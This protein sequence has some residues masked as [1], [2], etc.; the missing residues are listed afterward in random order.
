[1]IDWFLIL[2][3]FDLIIRAVGNPQIYRVGCPK[4]YQKYN[5]FIYGKLA[6]QRWRCVQNCYSRVLAPRQ[7]CPSTATLWC[8]SEILFSGISAAAAPSKHRDAV[9]HS[10]RMRRGSAISALRCYYASRTMR[11]CFNAAAAPSRRRGAIPKICP[12]WFF[13]SFSL[14][15]C[16]VL[17]F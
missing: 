1:M 6:S 13:N 5:V 11:S 3:W 16:S 8:V 2:F 14:Y 10:I 15:S 12:F 9:M 7:C 17:I 4:T